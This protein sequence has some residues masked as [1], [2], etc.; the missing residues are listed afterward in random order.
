M[1]KEELIRLI[2]SLNLSNEDFTIL[3]SGALV[4]RG[5]LDIAHD[6]DIAVSENGLNKLSENFDLISKGNN[7]YTVN[8]N[9]ECVLDNMEGKKE[10]VDG[11]YLHD[12]NQYLKEMESSNKEKHKLRIPL[13]KKYINEKYY[14]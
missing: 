4:I 11:Y 13:V 7:W 5:I 8:E 10:L 3:S 9:I 1:N 6:L 12:I 14:K 2:D